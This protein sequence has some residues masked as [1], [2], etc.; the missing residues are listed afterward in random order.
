[1]GVESRQCDPPVKVKADKAAGMNVL[2]YAQSPPA[3][4]LKNEEILIFKD[5]LQ[6]LRLLEQMSWHSSKM[7]KS[8]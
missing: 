5:R 3:H 6:L 1:M 7:Q 2:G 4:K 8:P